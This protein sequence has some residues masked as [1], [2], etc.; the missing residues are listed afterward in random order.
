MRHHLVLVPRGEREWGHILIIIGDSFLAFN[1]FGSPSLYLYGIPKY[2]KIM[3]FPSILYSML[4]GGMM[5]H[6][7][8]G[9]HRTK[10]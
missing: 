8:V 7:L 5:G 9:D 4:M 2:L 10:Y 1:S 3:G 6:G